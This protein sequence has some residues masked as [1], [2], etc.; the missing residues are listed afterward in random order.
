MSSYIV[1]KYAAT[2]TKYD[3]QTLFGWLKESYGSLSKAAKKIGIRRKTVYDWDKINSGLKLLTK[4]KVLEANLKLY[5]DRTTMFLVE[6][7]ENSYQEIL[8]T[9]LR[10][11]FEKAMAS[12]NREH[13]MKLLSVFA[14]V[15][16]DH[17][18]ALFDSKTLY[19]E[20]KIKALDEKASSFGMQGLEPSIKT[21]KPEILA[22]KFLV[23]LDVL[24]EGRMSMAELPQSI[25]LPSDYIKAI[26]E[27]TRYT[28]PGPLSPVQYLQHP[29]NLI[30]QEV[31]QDTGPKVQGVIP[32]GLES[33]ESIKTFN[34]REW[35][36]W[37]G[38]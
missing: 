14:E 8:A 7:S 27:R 2:L 5:P 31:G 17:R 11:I 37:K 32:V 22:Q 36:K 35:K 6:K 29:V 9:H 12:D 15:Q 28:E 20:S 16:S 25:G 4:R 23:L 10:Q 33:E 38:K 3:V 24:Y 26:A 21:I 1:D 34:R 13:F 30:G 18:G 19:V